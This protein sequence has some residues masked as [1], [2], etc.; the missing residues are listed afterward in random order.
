[1]LDES[2]LRVLGIILPRLEHLPHPWAVTGSLGLSLQGIEVDVHDID[3]QS[4]KEGAFAIENVLEEYVIHKV[5]YL[6]SQRIRSFL[7]ELKMDGIKVEIMGEVQKRLQGGEWESQSDLSHSIHWV[8]LEG[9]SVPVFDLEF[10]VRA[11]R[12]LG[13]EEKVEK[14]RAAL[15]ERKESE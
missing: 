4:S 12:M 15:V 5:E 10:E 6:E 3:L 13:R 8:R 14:I 1:M 9:L 7:G 2:Y 11:Y